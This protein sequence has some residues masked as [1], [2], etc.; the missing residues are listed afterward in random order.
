MNKMMHVYL[1]YGERSLFGLG[2]GTRDSNELAEE[3]SHVNS[4]NQEKNSERC[5]YTP[6]R[7]LV[8]KWFRLFCS[9][10]QVRILMG[11]KPVVSEDQT[12][13]SLDDRNT[14]ELYIF[15]N[16]CPNLI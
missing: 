6:T 15:Y 14:L 8:G 10:L 13:F 4:K 11:P 16:F 9:W 7:L 3:C 1:K 2:G 5:V 12:G